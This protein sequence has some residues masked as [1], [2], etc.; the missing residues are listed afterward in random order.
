MTRAA[1]STTVVALLGAV[2]AG[3]GITGVI[4]PGEPSWHFSDKPTYLPQP[5][6]HGTKDGMR[7]SMSAAN[8][9]GKKNGW[10]NL[11]PPQTSAAVLLRVDSSQHYL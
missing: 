11:W 4:A 5:Q 10:N 8:L 2:L 1:P 7:P 6:L 3:I 9:I